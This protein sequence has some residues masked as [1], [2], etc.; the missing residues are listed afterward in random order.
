MFARQGVQRTSLQDIANRLGITKPALYYHFSSREDLVRSIVQPLI[1]EGDELV[2]RHERRNVVV[3][4]ELLTDYFD[5]HYR[6][7]EKLM[8]VLAELRILGE[9]ESIDAAL[10]W[11]R[12]L[13]RLVF[14]ADPTLDQA[15]RAIMAFGGIQDCCLQLPEVPPERLR[16]AAVGAALTVL[17]AAGNGTT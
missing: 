2:V 4:S 5:F 10:D 6:H 7:R 14:G 11:R 8:L 17:G 3:V 12:R 9:V 16:T 15:A 13:V 1:Q